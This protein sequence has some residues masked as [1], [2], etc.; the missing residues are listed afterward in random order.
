MWRFVCLQFTIKIVQDHEFLSLNIVFLERL[1]TITFATCNIYFSLLL[2][3][4][5]F[6]MLLI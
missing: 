3:S 4:Y 5:Y 6:W 1:F 2:V